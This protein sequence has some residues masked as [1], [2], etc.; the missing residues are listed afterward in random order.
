LNY[1]RAWPQNLHPEP[2]RDFNPDYILINWSDFAGFEKFYRELPI[3][4]YL[5]QLLNGKWGYEVLVEHKVAYFGDWLYQA[6]DREFIIELLLLK[7]KFN[8]EK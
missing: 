7:K 5:H 1:L 2:V 6:L 8:E 3:D 4:D